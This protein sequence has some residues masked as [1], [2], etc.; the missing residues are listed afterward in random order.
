[1]AT[2]D[3]EHTVSASTPSYSIASAASWVV[4]AAVRGVEVRDVH[5]DRHPAGVLQSTNVR[6]LVTPRA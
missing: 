1:M 3:E 5:K 2:F 4:I 6:W